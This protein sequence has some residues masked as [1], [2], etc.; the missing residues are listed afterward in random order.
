MKTT[1]RKMLNVLTLAAMTLGLVLV[2]TGS[3]SALND[4]PGSKDAEVLPSIAGTDAHLD[5]GRQ[6]SEMVPPAMRS[7]SREVEVHLPT[8]HPVS[9]PGTAR[10]PLQRKGGKQ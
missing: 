7:R 3:V 6:Q 2:S 9:R 1:A 4:A 8:K 10:G 5:D